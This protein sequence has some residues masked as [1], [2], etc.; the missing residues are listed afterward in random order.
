MRHPPN[1]WL[2]SDLG[3]R[4]ANLIRIGTVVELDETAARVRVTCGAGD[5]KITT[6]WLPWV[7]SRAG[8]D[9]T[10]W[11]LE[12][13]EQV[14]ILSPSGEMAQ[15]VVAG[16]LYRDS[17]PPPASS[18]DVRRTEF[19]GGSFLEHDRKAGKMRLHVE[20]DLEVTVSGRYTCLDGA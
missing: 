9:R 12:P 16:S 19:E 18:K 10:W 14:L 1:D 5:G 11:A 2:V 8:P 15:G 20:G 6:A 13:G 17:Y 4:I 3:R 7:T